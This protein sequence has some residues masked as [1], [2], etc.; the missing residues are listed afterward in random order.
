MITVHSDVTPEKPTGSEFEICSVPFSPNERMRV[1]MFEFDESKVRD[2]PMVYILSNEKEAYVGK[3]T[4]VLNR[5]NQHGSNPEKRAFNTVHVIFNKEF[6][7]SVVESY[8]HNLIQLMSADGRYQLTNKNEGLDSSDYFAKDEYDA[9]FED[10]WGYLKDLEL[11]EHSIREI[12]ESEVF[13]YSPFKGL[14]V[15]QRLALDKIMQAIKD[16]LERAA[17]IVVEGVPGTGK[18]ILAIYLLKALHDDPDFAD[19]KVKL[20]EPMTALRE[21]LRRTVSGVSNIKKKDVLGI[22]DINKSEKGYVPGE[23]KSFD[24]MLVDETHR[25]K[26]RVNLGRQFRNYDKVNETLGLEQ[27]AT[28]LD[29]VLDQAKLPIFFYDPMQTVLPADVSREILEDRLGYA[30]DNPIRLESQMRVRGGEN[31][32]KYIKAILMNESPVPEHFDEYEFELYD[33]FSAFVDAFEEK[34]GEFDLTR[35]LAG[36]A[37]P[38]ASQN[39]SDQSIFDI[40]IDGIR[41]RW[42]CRPDNWVG[43]GVRDESGRIAREV[44]CIHSIQGYDLS[45]AFVIIGG[46]LRY[47]P[48]LRGV[49]G[50]PDGYFDA[51]GRASATQDE[52]A[53]YIR[54]IYYVLLTRGIL[55]THVYVCDSELREYLSQYFV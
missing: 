24:I 44:G 54:N 47:D 17:P 4:S 41:K 20:V 39:N 13:K 38:W 6:N 36:Y 8:E 22:Y 12:E 3:T 49:A 37:W 34:I 35:M 48:D 53:G 1:S 42:N 55:G 30:L 5:M 52:V 19:M 23:E 18:T 25:L 2:W 11:A 16:G 33:Q 31:Y 46:D 32:L 9:M 43:L 10:L 28:Q 14:S 45:H 40:E 15:D 26:Q 50:N 7:V 51:N 27:D 29:W 21:T